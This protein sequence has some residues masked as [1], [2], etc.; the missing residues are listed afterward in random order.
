MK[1]FFLSFIVMLFIFGFTACDNGTDIHGDD[2]NN[3]ETTADVVWKNELTLPINPALSYNYM[4]AVDENNNIYVLM[5]NFEGG[6]WGGYAM[7]KFDKDGKEL[8]VKQSTEA[9]CTPHNQMPTFYKNNLYFTTDAKVI[10]LDASSGD[11]KWEYEVPD[12]MQYITPAIAVVNDMILITLEPFT[13]EKS[14]L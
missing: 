1:H 12:S 8:W 7:Q 9:G 6:L 13:A 11:S 14:Y 2:P 10:C 4:P 5:Q 3:T